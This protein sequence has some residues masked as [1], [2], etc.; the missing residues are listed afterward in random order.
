MGFN[1]FFILK[2]ARLNSYR[3]SAARSIFWGLAPSPNP[4]RQRRVSGLRF[5]IRVPSPRQTMLRFE[6]ASHPV[7]DMIQVVFVGFERTPFT[8]HFN[9]AHGIGHLAFI[10]YYAAVGI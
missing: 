4:M 9:S 8:L 6:F 5:S 1:L 2:I 3:R 7:A 10:K